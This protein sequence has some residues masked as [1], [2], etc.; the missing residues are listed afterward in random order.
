[1]SDLVT[2]RLAD[3]AALSVTLAR[4][5]AAFGSTSVCCVRVAVL[6]R[7]PG[8]VTVA[9]IVSVAVAAGPVSLSV[10]TVHADV[11]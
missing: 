5:L 2:V 9:M 1:M 3:S 4:S 6:T 10:P 8:A 11:A 7:A